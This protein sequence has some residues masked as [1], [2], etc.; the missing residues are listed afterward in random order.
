M[1]QKYIKT[2]YII[3]Q[4]W[5]M[6]Q[7][8]E[9]LALWTSLHFASNIWLL[10]LKIFRDSKVII[11]EVNF[12]SWLLVLDLDHSCARI[13]YLNISFFIVNFQHAYREYNHILGFSPWLLVLDLDHSCDRI[14][15]LNISFFTLN[16]QHVCREYNH[17]VDK[18]Y[19]KALNVDKGCLI[20]LEYMKG[21]LIHEGSQHI[22]N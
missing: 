10:K 13:E 7:R 18:L 8:A 9:L 14:E 12:A 1:S 19:K 2:V 20:F 11:N 22:F 15:Y 16:F 21:E 17:M 6:W 3:L 5:G 4:N